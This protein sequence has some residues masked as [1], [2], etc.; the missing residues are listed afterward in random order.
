MEAKDALQK[1]LISQGSKKAMKNRAQFP[2][3]AGLRTLSELTKGLTKAGI[4]PSRLHDRVAVIAKVAGAKRKR[5]R[6]EEDA[7]MDV[8]G[9]GEADAEAEGGDWM[10]VDG[11]DAIPNKRTKANSGG[12]VKN[13]REPRTNRQFAGLRDDAVSGPLCPC[14]SLQ[15]LISFFILASIQGCQT[16]QPRSE[17]T[18]HAREGWRERSCD[19]DQDGESF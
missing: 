19:Q 18:Q 17:R 15:I 14:P 3:T 7:E 10:D 9:E 2:R 8:D 5:Q 1:K 6:D 4:D 13:Q 11:E 12:A 16:A